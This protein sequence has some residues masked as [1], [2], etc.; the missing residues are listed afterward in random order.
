MSRPMETEPSREVSPDSLPAG[1]GMAS[2]ALAAARGAT[3]L[4]VLQSV[5]RALS[6]VFVA[7]VTRQLGP[8]GFGR[9]SAAAAI[10][11]VGNVLADLGT[12]S[13]M[14]RFVSRR[15][16]SSNDLLSGTIP[17]S[18]GLGLLAY[19]MAVAFAAVSYPAERI[20]D[21]SI[22]AVAIPAAAVLSS[23]LAA[24]DGVGLIARRALMTALQTVIVSLGVIPI[25]FGFGVRSAIAALAAAPVVVLL[26]AVIEARRTGIWRCGVRYDHARVI[27]L[28]RAALPFALSGGLSA[29]IMRFD[30]IFLS[31]IKTPAE[32][33][34]YDLA[35]R[36]V[37]SATYLSTAVCAPLLFILNRRLAE[38]NR[39]GAIR[40]YAEAMRVLYLIGLPLSAG[41]VILAKPIVSVA[42]GGAFD[43]V[44]APLAIMGAGVWLTFVVFVQGALVM[45]GDAVGRGVAV[46]A[47]NAAVTVLLDLFLVPVY[48]AGG[49]AVA[50]LL[51]WAFS[52][53]AFDVFHRRVSGI[54][55]PLPSFRAV[56]ATVGAATVL[57]AFRNG[58]VVVS[59][60]AGAC[61][62]LALLLA[63][64][65]VGRHDLRRLRIILSGS[66][67]GR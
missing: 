63:T 40:A 34:S 47:L 54:A 17:A 11:L 60:S 43:S 31:V 49:A 65:V 33:A 58:P 48:G 5:A 8:S 51:S 2:D 30:V 45:S 42:L 20:I 46:G 44:V 27:T 6:L 9:Y 19:V 7:L 22:G 39:D 15:P 59:A 1:A 25:L 64:G 67:G 28:L 38:G 32:T 21:I 18:L 36:L 56:V 37:E 3:S 26:V 13:A 62:Y 24:F 50:M 23:V 41:I 12:S 52:A 14:T 10:V 35:L 16:S 4:M 61:T 57:V 29:L 55:T 66:S 53:I